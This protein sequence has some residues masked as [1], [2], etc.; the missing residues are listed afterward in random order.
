MARISKLFDLSI[1]IGSHGFPCCPHVIMGI[2][3]SGSENLILDGL[4]ASRGLSVDFSITTC[5][6]LPINCCIEGSID[7]CINGIRVHRE[8]DGV[9]EKCGWGH[10]LTSS[11]DSSADSKI[12]S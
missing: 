2:R 5:P 10:T 12:N 11:A 3:M 1:G 7:S 6:H 4:P 9:N 8:G